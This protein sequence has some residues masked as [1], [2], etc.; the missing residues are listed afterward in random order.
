M[1]RSGRKVPLKEWCDSAP[2]SD[3]DVDGFYCP[4]IKAVKD[5]GITDGCGGGKFCG[6]DWLSRGHL[7]V[8]LLRGAH[9]PKRGFAP[10]TNLPKVSFAPSPLSSF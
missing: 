5:I 6:D 1:R 3:V 8:F 4:Y 7:A 2:F 10:R 9:Y